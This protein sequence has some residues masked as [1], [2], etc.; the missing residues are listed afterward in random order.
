[1]LLPALA[2]AAELAVPGSR[3][4]PDK[5]SPTPETPAEKVPY[6]QRG[7]QRWF[8]ATSIDVGFEY[9]RPRLSVGYGKPHYFW[10]GLEANPIVA[11]D[12]TGTY[13]GVR[14]AHPNVDLRVGGRYTYSFYRSFL[15]IQD[16]YDRDDIDF[17]RDQRAA[18]LALESE[19]T[20]SIP[21]GPGAVLGEYAATRVGGI[22]DDRYVY[23][24]TLR[25]ILGPPWVFRLRNGYTVGIGATSALS[26]GLVGEIVLIP[27]RDATLFRAGPV[28]RWK[29]FDD[30]EARLTLVPVFVSPDRLGLAGGDFGHMGLRWRWAT[31]AP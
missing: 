8:L 15:P 6:W 16:S 2:P 19:L 20:Y 30:L 11:A 21:L 24:E 13:G 26:I 17:R 23:L 1:M 4:S 12:S 22:P 31:G 7:A 18:Y 29:L 14:F 9:L 25:L 3:P 27:E 28:A 5:R 10:A